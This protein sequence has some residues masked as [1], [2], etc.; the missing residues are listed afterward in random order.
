M[1]T[2]FMVF[3]A[4]LLCAAAFYIWK[5]PFMDI[6]AR[7]IAGWQPTEEFTPMRFANQKPQPVLSEAL[8]RPLFRRSRRPYD[9]ASAASNIP[10]PEPIQIV[11]QAPSIDSSQFTVKGIV[12]NNEI[13]LALITTPESPEGNWIGL[14]TDV[15]G[16]KLTEITANSVVLSAGEQHQKLKLYVDNGAN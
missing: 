1:I 10:P 6:Q 16:W 12:I 14:E 4:T 7:D 2:G 5:Q 11:S 8:T 9:P 13:R 3:V 15:M